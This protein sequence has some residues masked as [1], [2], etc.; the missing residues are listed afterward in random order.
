[1]TDWTH[2]RIENPACCNNATDEIAAE[3]RAAFNRRKDTYPLL[4]SGGTITAEEARDDLE[5]WRAIAKDWHWIAFGEGEPATR[6]TL[7]SRIA[8][9]DTAINRWFTQLDG[10]GQP[11]SE[12]EIDQLFFLAAMRWWAEREKTPAPMNH[13]RWAASVMHDWRARNGHPTRGQ[14]LAARAQPQNKDAA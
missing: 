9:L 14:M 3:A 7:I 2:P 5:A 4:V 12:A 11:P 8:A 10:H 13:I 6:V 1:M